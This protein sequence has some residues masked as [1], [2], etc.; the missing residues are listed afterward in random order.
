MGLFTMQMQCQRKCF[1]LSSI[2][3]HQMHFLILN[4]IFSTG[5]NK[6]YFELICVKFSK[7]HRSAIVVNNPST[8]RDIFIRTAEHNRDG[9]RWVDPQ[10]GDTDKGAREGVLKIGPQIDNKAD[11]WAQTEISCYSAW[12]RKHIIVTWSIP[13]QLSTDNFSYAP[14]F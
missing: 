10:R 9:H 11:Y 5:S 8:P 13:E 2:L 4:S 6:K 14:T 7:R 3:Q 12:E 1:G